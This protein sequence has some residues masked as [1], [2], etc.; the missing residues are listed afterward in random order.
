MER[1]RKTHNTIKREL[2]A[3]HVSGGAQVLDLG[4]GRGGDLHKWKSVGANV[5]MIDPCETSINDAKE[6]QKSLGTKYSFKVGDVL[7]APRK[8]YDVVCS[9]FSIQYVFKNKNYMRKCLSAIVQR[10]KVGGKFIGCVPDSDFI[11]MNPQFSDELGNFFKVNTFSDVGDYVDVMLADTP[12]YNGKVIPEPIAHKDI[13]ITFM[14]NKGLLLTEW[15]PIMKER[16]H[17][18]S[19]MYSKFCFVKVR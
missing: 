1:I 8:E 6:R 17:I 9:N 13:F 2:I 5:F 10:L 16:S 11:R 15:E 19:D 4:C 3:T 12:Y 7:S 14:E 18:I